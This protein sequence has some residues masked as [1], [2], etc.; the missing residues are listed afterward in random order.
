M[1]FYSKIY[2]GEGSMLC[3]L[4]DLK[5]YKGY[6][7]NVLNGNIISYEDSVINNLATHKN[8]EDKGMK[9]FLS[10]ILSHNSSSTY[11]CTRYLMQFLNPEYKIVDGYLKSFDAPL[12]HSWIES[13]D[14]VYDTLFVGVWPK[15]LFY[16]VTKPE[17]IRVVDSK[18][19]EEYKRIISKTIETKEDKSEFGYVDW[20][21]YMKDNSINTRALTYPKRIRKFNNE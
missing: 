17:I 1:F 13:E 12:Y 20:Y 5:I 2:N 4:N 6:Y 7:D 15:E 3:S 8:K 14:K 16:E 21:N 18:K 19:D 10:T 11:L 9:S